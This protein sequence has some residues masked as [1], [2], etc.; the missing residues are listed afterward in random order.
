MRLDTG[1]VATTLRLAA[2]SVLATIAVP[3]AAGLT[4]DRIFQPPHPPLTTAGLAPDA[5]LIAVTT[6][7]GL[8]LQGIVEPGRDDRPLIVLFHGNAS[9]AQA[10]L[11]WLAPLHADGYGFVAAEYR[12]YS[13]NPGSPSESG[14]ARDADA[15]L[16]EAR[17]LAAG[18]PIWVVGH[19][20]GGG[21][22]VAL[23]R[24]ERFAALVT[25]STFTSTRALAPRLARGLI[26]DAFD[27]LVA[28]PQLDVPWVIVHARD[29]AVVPASHGGALYL[30]AVGA[31]RRGA[32]VVL[33]SGGHQPPADHIRRLFARIPELIAD[34]PPATAV[35]ERGMEIVRFD[36]PR[37]T[38]HPRP[39]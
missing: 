35:A 22:A 5:R 15:F 12:G 17:R 19:S 8:T 24:R 18:R 6:A 3:A 2:L 13:A 26:S 21:V 32:G 33:A 29:D 16:A 4:R 36:D 23:A 11:A 38:P 28:A 7:D 9:S 27:N 39:H 37:N 14:L 30:A 1:R 25:I 20:L 34:Q 31:M 10:A